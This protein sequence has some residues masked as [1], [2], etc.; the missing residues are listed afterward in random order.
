M[1][2]ITLPPPTY[3]NVAYG[4][5][6]RHV[7]D[8]WQ[9]EAPRPTSLL[10]FIHGGGFRGGDK[11][12]LDP[13]LLRQCREAGIAVA[14][15]NYRL[16]QHAIYPAPFLDSARAIQF[17]RT[18]AEEWRLDP[19]R[20]AATGG[21]AGGGI[22]LWLGFRDD[23]ADAASPDP[24]ARRS[25]RLSCMVV[26]NTQTSYDP[27]FIKHIIP[28]EAYRHPALIQLFGLADP[29]EADTPPPEKARLFEHSSPI[30][31]VTADDPP[32]YLVYRQANAPLPP[33]AEAGPGIHH[34]QFGVV[35]KQRLDALGIECV[36]RC[37]DE[38][39]EQPTVLGFLRQH[40]RVET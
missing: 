16:S 12:N 24:V 38:P 37:G 7:L 14:A 1:D 27:R 11:R 21:S 4:P 13:H 23:L 2:E 9:A 19:R 34:P 30:N 32:V 33:D 6:E 35:L 31:Y 29:E 18:R 40:L 8:L 28:G 3:T 10:V 22:S 15:I 20:F 17:L 5:H 36:L 25:T 39:R 26:F